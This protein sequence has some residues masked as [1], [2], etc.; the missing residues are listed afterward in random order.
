LDGV[1]PAARDSWSEEAA[2][3]DNL[4]LLATVLCAT[5]TEELE[6]LAAAAEIF[7]EAETDV[8]ELGA[9]ELD[10]D[11]LNAGEDEAATLWAAGV[12]AE[13]VS[14]KM[15]AALGEATVWSVVAD[16]AAG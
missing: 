4:G 1:G 12:G 11:E 8:D 9:D 2:D 6:E 14:A 3:D 7:E 15:L 16:T 5:G 10:A 13:L